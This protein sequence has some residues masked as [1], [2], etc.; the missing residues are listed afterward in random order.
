MLHIMPTIRLSHAPHSVHLAEATLGEHGA[1]AQ[2]RSAR[3]RATT[4]ADQ[5]RTSERCLTDLDL[6]RQPPACGPPK[7]SIHAPQLTIEAI[8]HRCSPAPPHAEPPP[9]RHA[10]SAWRPLPQSG[11]A[12]SRLSEH[13]CLVDCLRMPPRPGIALLSGRSG[14]RHRA[15]PMR[16]ASADLHASYRSWCGCHASRPESTVQGNASIS[17]KQ[18]ECWGG[19]QGRTCWKHGRSAPARAPVLPRR[20]QVVGELTPSAGRAG[21][22]LSS[23]F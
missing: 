5:S 14:D 9:T 7:A 6:T 1:P 4:P 20:S 15:E 22:R 17:Q 16:P 2:V 3:S 13:C 11:A 12:A 23:V 10:G 19:T 21:R 18:V 8:A